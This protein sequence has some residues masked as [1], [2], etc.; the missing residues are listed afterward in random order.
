MRKLFRYTNELGTK[1]IEWSII[2]LLLRSDHDVDRANHIQEIQAHNF[3][4][5]PLDPVAIN[6]GTTTLRHYDSEARM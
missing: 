2:C 1:L 5:S 4:D 3:A 6:C